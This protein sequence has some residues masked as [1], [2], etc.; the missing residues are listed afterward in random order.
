MGWKEGR[1]TRV[2]GGEST[3]G[4]RRGGGDMGETRVHGVE[5]GRVHGREG[6]E[7]RVHGVEGGRGTW[8]GRRGGYMLRK[9]GKVHGVEGGEGTWGGRR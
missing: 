1:G 5:G 7:G 2:E 4:G 3:W 8:G 9:E 6:K